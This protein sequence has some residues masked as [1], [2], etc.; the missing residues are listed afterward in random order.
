MGRKVTFRSSWLEKVVDDIIVQEWCTADPSDP[1]KAKCITCPAGSHPFGLT[2]SIKEGF[3]AVE[4]HSKSRKHQEHY[5]PGE[6]REDDEFGQISIEAALKAQGDLN[7]RQHTETKQLLEGQTLFANFVHTHGLPSSSFTCFGALA[8]KIFPDSN[9]A[10]RWSGSKDGMRQTKG[11]YFLTHGV[12]EFHHKNLIK[13]LKSNFFSVNIDESSVN[14]KSQLDVNVSYIDRENSKAIKENFTII[15]MEKGTSASEIVEALVDEFDSCFIPLKNII[16]IVTDGCSTMLGEDGGV[17]ALLRQRLPH[18]PHWGGCS[19]HDCSNILK[20]GVSKLNSNLTSLF[21]QLH[22]YLSTSTLHRKREYEEFCQS[23]GLEPHRIPDFL[24]VRFRTITSCAEWMEKDDRCLYR[25]FEKLTKDIKKGT[26]KDISSSEHFILK[27]FC[28]NYLTVRLCNKFIIDVSDPI[29]TCINHFESEE[30][31]IFERFD[32]LADFL[33]TFMAKFLK[34]GGK[35]PDKTEFTTKDLLEVDVTDPN[36]Q[37]SN[38]DMYLGPKVEAFLTELNLTRS[39]PELKP[40]LEKVREFYCEALIKAQKYF[41]PPLSSKVL[42]ACDVFD[43]KLLFGT[44]LDEVKNKFKTVAGRF[45]N[46][47][48]LVEIPELLEQISS[49]HARADVREFAQH[50]TPVQIFSRL[51][52]WRSGKY[53]LVGI[54]GCAVL[55]IHNSGSM[56]ERDFSLQVAKEA[57]FMLF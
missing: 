1:F 3:G 12:Y 49:L 28:S 39:S 4:K 24:D 35:K 57:Y 33:V 38:K 52:T 47:I 19:C 37:L 14:S 16:T 15:S 32:V 9:I 25:W 8:E 50:M 42:R 13:K 51:V 31:K 2:F 34:N 44:D 21:S 56:A 48:K 23:L 46:V 18:L 53:Q 54:L 5:R 55:S 40:W 7:E 29:M 30:P 43:P 41:R 45:N 27:E 20:A 10:K 17:H 22:T 36:L 6:D 26:H 11:D